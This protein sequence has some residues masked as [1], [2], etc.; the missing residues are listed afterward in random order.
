MNQLEQYIYEQLKK[1]YTPDQIRSFLVSRGYEQKEVESSIVNANNKFL[2]SQ[3]INYV[4]S[5]LKQGYQAQQIH[6]QLI[7][8]GYQEKSVDL[9]FNNVNKNIYGGKLNVT[10]QHTVSNN[11]IIKIGAMLLVVAI[12]IGGG[13]FSFQHFSGNDNVKL[14]DI[15]SEATQMTIK[16]NDPLKFRLTML[17]QGNPGRVDIYLTYTIE[18]L[19]G[20][21]VIQKQ[22]TKAFETTIR[23]IV[24]VQ[25]PPDI[26]DG[27]YIAKIEANY[28]D[29]SAISSFTFYISKN[30][31]APKNTDSITTPTN[32]DINKKIIDDAGNLN[33][34]QTETSQTETKTYKPKKTPKIKTVKIKDKESDDDIFTKAV[35][36]KD[37]TTSAAYC[38]QINKAILKDE[39]FVYLASSSKDESYCDLV[40]DQGRKEDCKI[41]FVLNGNTSLCSEIT[42]DENKQLCAQFTQ[43]NALYN[44]GKT[45]DVDVLS[46]DLHVQAIPP[47]TPTNV[48]TPDSI[49][50][51]DIGDIVH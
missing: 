16:P 35:T 9:A 41:G 36:E 46:G 50:D 22:E 15:S 4:S 39:C 18:T 26:P 1:A 13:F 31:L 32:P 40:N 14:L 5:T 11:S 23:D 29:Q 3:L 2:E 8:Q 24:S 20:N 48:T 42:L 10:H 27:A 17:N 30:G 12:I 44:Y 43:M 33:K 21:R 38:Q 34:T 45:G 28:K 7:Q 6:D 37:A 49:N 25:L 19:G 47:Q 51:L